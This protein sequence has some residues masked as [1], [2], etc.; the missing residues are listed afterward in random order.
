MIRLHRE[1]RIIIPV[2]FL[3]L[4]GVWSALYF[5]F[6][7]G[8]SVWWMGVVLGLAA[9]VF[10]GLVLNFFRNPVI[11]TTSLPGGIIAPADGKVVVIEDIE[12]PIFFKGKVKQISIFMSPLNVHVNRNPI[13]GK[14]KF[15]KYSPGKYLVA[16]HPKSS[17]E[18]EQTFTAIEAADGTVVGFKQIAGAVA[19]RI[20]WYVKEGDQVE[21]AA[22]MGFIKFGSRIDILVPVTTQVDVS[23]NQMVAGGVTVIGMLPGKKR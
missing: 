8:T 21:Q 10:F 2:S 19:R 7:R 5:P 12:D 18:N 4:A 17:T 23:L 20:C 6:L 22:E 13:S 1:G 11:K 9:I 15:F 3:L 16:W 14:V